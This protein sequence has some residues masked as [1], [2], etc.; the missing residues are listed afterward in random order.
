LVGVSIANI[1]IVFFD[2]LVKFQ[3]IG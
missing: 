1:N 3:Q 2:Y